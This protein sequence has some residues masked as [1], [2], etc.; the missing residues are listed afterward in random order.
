MGFS[1]DK[2]DEIR[3]ATDIVE[4]IS[5]YLPLKRTGKYY[6]ALCPFHSE[7]KPSFNVHP[8]RQI[9]H[10][11]GCGKGG[12]VFSFLMEYEK[13]SFPEAVEFLARRSGIEVSR[14][15]KRDGVADSIYS[16]NRF[17]AEFYHRRLMQSNS[18]L[19]Y[20]ASRRIDRETIE[21]FMLGFAPDSW[22]ELIGAARKREVPMESLKRAGLVL[23]GEKTSYDAFRKR[24]IFPIFNLSDR[25]VGFGARSIDD[26]TPKYIN[27]S[28]TP[29]YK[30]GEILFGLN[31]SKAY[32]RREGHGLLVEGYTDFIALW[33]GGMLNCAAL[34]GTAFTSKQARL[35]ARYCSGVTLVY[36]SDSAGAASTSRSIDILL[37]QDLDVRV[38]L[39]PEGEDPDSFIRKRGSDELRRL[40]G[41]A[42]DWLAFRLRGVGQSDVSG[43][44]GIVRSVV[45]SV[46]RI[47]DSIKRR[48]WLRELARRTGIEEGIL[49]RYEGKGSQSVE[50]V[51]GFNA[52]RIE[53]ELLGMMASDIG[54]LSKVRSALEID[55]FSLP[56]TRRLASLLF[57][58][59]EEASPS[60]IMDGIQD[61]GLRDFLGRC[62]FSVE[63]S[64]SGG[65]IADDYIGKMRTATIDRRLREVK[66]S[67]E[68]GEKKGIL[69]YDLLKEHQRLSEMK[70]GS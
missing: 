45:Q 33:G 48:L 25:V 21:E 40:I 7:K 70:R 8:E 58:V 35:L 69:D 43:K 12:N 53:S 49:S 56:L 54:I 36:D 41:E 38:V 57:G 19:E 11:F 6:R 4:L 50:R 5:E 10:C 28:E 26:S 16:A 39:L 18:A 37:E 24:L 22:N 51:H 44:A 20:A 65:E 14:Y 55:D 62:V 31:R 29:V 60:A 1:K 47:P 67:I 59:E 52:P 63:S 3:Q 32:M 23:T 64:P 13:L 15:E 2:I 68:E 9:Y 66:D 46:L 17:A 61:P 27:T 34:C 42:S 30:K